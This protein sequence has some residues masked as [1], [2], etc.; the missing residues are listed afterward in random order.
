METGFMF[1]NTELYLNCISCSDCVE[2]LPSKD[3]QSIED[4]ARLWTISEKLVG[5]KS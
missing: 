4:A 2:K 1:N 5:I 3:A